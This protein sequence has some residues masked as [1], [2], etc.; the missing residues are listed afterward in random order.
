MFCRHCGRRTISGPL[1]ALGRRPIHCT[2]CRQLAPSCRC[3]PRPDDAALPTVEALR[4]RDK[5]VVARLLRKGFEPAVVLAVGQALDA[6]RPAAT[7]APAP[8]LPTV[9]ALRAEVN[10]WWEGPMWP[11]RAYARRVCEVM[12]WT[13]P[14]HLA[15]VLAA[16]PAPA[17]PRSEA[18]RQ[19]QAQGGGDVTAVMVSRSDE[20]P[21][22]APEARCSF[23]GLTKMAGDHG[24]GN[25]KHHSFR[26]AP[27]PEGIEVRDPDDEVVAHGAFVHVERLDDDRVWMSIATP[28][29]QEVHIDVFAQ[30]KRRV[31]M[32][33]TD[34]GD[35]PTTIPAP[36]E[37]R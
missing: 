18:V 32:S 5:E 31:G 23:C 26:P 16:T 8:T 6:T 3:D 11:N 37:D 12:G 28:N 19:Q 9:E 7:P 2:G 17:P 24:A 14:D 20:T 30:P 36:A 25:P 1:D 29:G 34:Q 13:G 15:P 21:A 4:A 22:P 10:R 35:T 27:A 33:V